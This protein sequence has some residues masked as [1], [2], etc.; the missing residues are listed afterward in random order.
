MTLLR[1]EAT[2]ISNYFDALEADIGHRGSSFSDI[3]AVSVFIAEGGRISAVSHDGRTKRFLFREFKEA[4]ERV[5]E[6][7]KRLLMG[8]AWLPHVRVW[9]VRRTE[10]GTVTLVEFTGAACTFPLELTPEQYR[11]RFAAWWEGR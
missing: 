5:S 6:G 8:L 9:L 3:D 2:A 1:R 7:Q 11:R 4:H 10:H